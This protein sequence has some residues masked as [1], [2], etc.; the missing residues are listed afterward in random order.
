M[1]DSPIGMIILLYEMVGNK[2]L[3]RIFW[4]NFTNIDRLVTKVGSNE[5]PGYTYDYRP[6]AVVVTTMVGG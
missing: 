2:N 1:S 6:F 5:A 3:S 4:K